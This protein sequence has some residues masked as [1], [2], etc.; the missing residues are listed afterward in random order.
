MCVE[1]MGTRHVSTCVEGMGTILRQVSLDV[2]GGHGNK[3]S[4]HMCRGYGNK[5]GFTCSL[6]PR[7][8]THMFVW[9]VW[10]QDM[11]HL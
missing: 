1:G 2:C 4:F 9:R 10:E 7:P 5:T 11:F 8:S 6:I 3:T